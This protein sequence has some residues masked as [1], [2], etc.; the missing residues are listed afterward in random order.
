MINFDDYTNENKTE[1]NRNWSYIPN[2]P[3][4]IL[5]I[6]GS[7]SGKTYALLNLIE[8][9]PYIDKIYLYAKDPYEAKYQYLI[10]KRESAGINHFSDPKAFI[11]YSNDMRDVYKNINYYNPDKENK[12]L[13]VFNDM[14]AD[15]VN[16]KKLH[17]VVTELLVRGRKLNI[18]LVYSA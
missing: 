8:D 2:K 4:R 7:G 10:N 14:I 9:Q 13:I 15:M 5:I 17:L 3:Y 12:I 6:G 16:N 11:E 18:F 1:H